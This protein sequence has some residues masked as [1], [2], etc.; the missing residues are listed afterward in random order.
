MVCVDESGFNTDLIRRYARAPR[1]ERAYG[2]APRNPGANLTLICALSLTGPQ[3]ALVIEGAVNGVV[4]ETWVRE[5]LCPTLQP[6]Q[7]VIMDNLASHHRATVRVLIE[8]CGCQL[9]YLPSYSPD[10][11]PIEMLFSK[12]KARLRGWGIRARELLIDAIG[13]ALARVTRAD[14]LGWFSHALPQ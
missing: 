12:L 13:H 10:F 14:C 6:G 5:V 2:Q 4:F 8:G 11:N 1:H 3:A 9:L 7:T